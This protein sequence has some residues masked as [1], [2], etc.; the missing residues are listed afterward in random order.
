MLITMCRVYAGVIK[1]D[2]RQLR[3]KEES[4]IHMMS[5]WSLHPTR[6]FPPR[7]K[8]SGQLWRFLSPSRIHQSVELKAVLQAALHC[9]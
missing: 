8:Q 6:C 1:D 4:E 9:A 7:D 2:R 3:G 5:A